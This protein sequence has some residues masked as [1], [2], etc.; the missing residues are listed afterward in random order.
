MKASVLYLLIL[1]CTISCAWA[2]AKPSTSD[3]E[4]KP[5]EEWGN[6]DVNYLLTDSPWSHTVKGWVQSGPLLVE[7]SVQFR[8]H[9]AIAIRFARL[10]KRQLE[11]KYDSMDAKA[12]ARFNQKYKSDLE[13][14]KC[15]ASYIVSILDD[16][17][18]LSKRGVVTGRKKHIYL[19]NDKGERR[20]LH[21]FMPPKTGGN[22]A[23]FF[24][25]RYDEKGEPLLKTDNET[26]VFNINVNEDDEPIF[27]L[28][29]RVS[30]NVREIVR[31]GK[32]VF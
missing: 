25:P 27:Q 28:L 10:R 4:T 17:R 2:Q 21:G 16:G 13:C 9:S 24:F 19:S 14:A 22:E 30:I 1:S 26:L 7:R 5:I 23:L 3:W 31:D 29:K 15:A 18:E 20:M 8:L 11:E 32:V 12:K 6:K